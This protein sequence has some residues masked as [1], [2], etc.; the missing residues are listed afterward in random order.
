MSIQQLFVHEKAQILYEC[1]TKDGIVQCFLRDNN[2]KLDMF[3]E[4][5]FFQN[6]LIQFE[7]FQYL[8]FLNIQNDFTKI[9]IVFQFYQR[10]EIIFHCKCSQIFLK[11]YQ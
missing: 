3:S 10:E 4:R 7:P 2:T 1:L 5:F 9:H 11:P 8:K 6:E